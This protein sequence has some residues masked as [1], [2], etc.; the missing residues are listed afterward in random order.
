MVEDAGRTPNLLL[1]RCRGNGD[2]SLLNDDVCGGDDSVEGAVVFVG[3]RF[4][5]LNDSPRPSFGGEFG[6]LGLSDGRNR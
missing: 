4:R 1:E 6:M 5:S 3:V 2:I